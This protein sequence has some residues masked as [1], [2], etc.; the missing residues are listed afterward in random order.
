MTIAQ[1]LQCKKKQI[2]KSKKQYKQ[3]QMWRNIKLC[4][5]IK[6]A[7]SYQS[8]TLLRARSPLLVPQSLPVYTCTQRKQRLPSV[9]IIRLFI[10]R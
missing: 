5:E 6:L 10:Q 9:N 8:R 3:K 2:A 7:L 4:A 1:V